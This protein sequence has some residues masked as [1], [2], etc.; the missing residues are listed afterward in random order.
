MLDL[1]HYMFEDDVVTASVE[2]SKIRQLARKNF[3]REVYGVDYIYALSQD[4]SAGGGVTLD[5]DM[6]LDDD[7]GDVQP[8]NPREQAK[9]K[10]YFAPTALKEDSVKPFGAVLDA[11]LG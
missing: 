2:Q 6:E 7:L 11:P 8:F 10:S 3:Y 5:D 1:I 9:T 4:D